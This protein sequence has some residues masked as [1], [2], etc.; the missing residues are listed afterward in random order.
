MDTHWRY[1]EKYWYKISS[2]WLKF[3]NVYFFNSYKGGYLGIIIN[4]IVFLV[5]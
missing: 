2:T 4:I 1:L 5:Q 3:Y